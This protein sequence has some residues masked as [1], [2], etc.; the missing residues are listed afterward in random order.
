MD[1]QVPQADISLAMAGVKV[2]N[3]EIVPKSSSSGSLNRNIRSRLHILGVASLA[4][5]MI[6]L[7]MT[8]PLQTNGAMLTRLMR[9]VHGLSD[10]VAVTSKPVNECLSASGFT[11]RV[12]L[13]AEAAYHESLQHN[14]RSQGVVG[15]KPMVMAEAVD[16]A[17]V[18]R[19]VRC[20][21]EAGLKVCARSG[22]GSFIGTSHCSVD[23][24]MLLDLHQ[25]KALSYDTVSGTVKLQMGL[26]VGQM[27]AG[28]DSQSNGEATLPAGICFGIGVGGFLLGGGM[29]PLDSMAGLLCDRLQEVQM[30]TASGELVKATKHERPDVMW[31]AC[32]GGGQ[33]LGVVVS[34]TLATFPTGMIG[35]S[36]CSRV[37]FD[38]HRAPEVFAVWQSLVQ[39]KSHLRFEICAR[40]GKVSIWGCVWQSCLDNLKSFSSK[41]GVN[42]SHDVV[43]NIS[44][45]DL[46][47]D[48]GFRLSET[49]RQ[50]AGAK[51]EFLMQFNRFIDTQKFLG[52]SGKWGRHKAEASDEAALVN[53]QWYFA[54]QRDTRSEKTMLTGPLSPWTNGFQQM[55]DLCGRGPGDGGWGVCTIIPVGR[56]VGRR[57]S[58][59]TAFYWRSARHS[60]QFTVGDTAT[61][62]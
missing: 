10:A 3:A 35:N 2:A 44:A 30:V 50:H 15:S 36:V 13:P 12:L 6:G 59:E 43:G 51:V 5:C 47:E 4:G 21:Q 33:A 46:L 48:L 8:F 58:D 14:F 22:G 37:S 40:T 1:E 41:G 18:Q 39:Y 60:I 62:A 53:N 17:D 29:S 38:V 45:T 25:L 23:P 9:G 34:A 32:G 52:P 26:T 24:A 16:V 27:L 19:A 7:A 55:V 31:A 42:S 56:A 61:D 57:A 49:V 11:G 20:A 28:V 54:R